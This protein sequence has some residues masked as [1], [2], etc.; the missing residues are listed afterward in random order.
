MKK[1]LSLQKMQQREFFGS[2][3]NLSFVCKEVSTVSLF[4][5]TPDDWKDN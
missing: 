2:T 4:L 3:S 5:C 1:V